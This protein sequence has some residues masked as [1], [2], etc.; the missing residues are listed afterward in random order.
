LARYGSDDRASALAMVGILFC[1]LIIVALYG[2]RY[3]YFMGRRPGF[4]YRGFAARTMSLLA[5]GIYFLAVAAVYF[6]D[7]R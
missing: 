4:I 5:I 3:E 2:L 7:L 6:S 1:P